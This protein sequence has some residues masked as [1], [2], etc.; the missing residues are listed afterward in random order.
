MK[1]INVFNQVIKSNSY[2]ISNFISTY[3]YTD[4]VIVGLIGH[5]VDLRV[6][7]HGYPGPA[8]VLLGPVAHPVAPIFGLFAP[9]VREPMQVYLRHDLVTV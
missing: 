6:V 9:P 5:F 8:A 7:K 1:F 3:Q 4:I 2:S